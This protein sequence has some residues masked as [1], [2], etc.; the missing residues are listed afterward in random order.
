MINKCPTL[1]TSYIF[2]YLKGVTGFSD[3]GDS[4]G[5]L[6]LFLADP[7]TPFRGLDGLYIVEVNDGIDLIYGTSFPFDNY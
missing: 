5:R 6:G 3:D 4:R 7:K 1:I 2:T